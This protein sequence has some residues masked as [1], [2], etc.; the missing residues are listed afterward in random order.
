LFGANSLG[1]ERSFAGRG[2]AWPCF[3]RGAGLDAPRGR[4]L[5]AAGARP[6]T[7]AGTGCR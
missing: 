3:A 6:V 7:D 5:D 4:G 2:Y 1:K